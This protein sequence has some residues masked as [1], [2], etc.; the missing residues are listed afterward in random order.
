MCSVEKWSLSPKIF[1]C[2]CL[3]RKE[4]KIF[5]DLCCIIPVIRLDLNRTSLFIQNDLC[6]REI[7]VDRPSL[8]TPFPDNIRQF[9][10]LQD[11]RNKLPIRFQCLGI[12]CENLCHSVITHSFIYADYC[13]SNLM[14]HDFAL[15]CHCHDT[16]QG[17]PVLSCIQRTDSI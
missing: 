10:H 11:H 14:I 9:F 16:G 8:C 1:L 15:R 12:P 13:F 7:K 2:N 4:H 5:Y 17:K 3:I 6:L